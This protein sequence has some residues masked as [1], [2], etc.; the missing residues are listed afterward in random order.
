MINT[1]SFII[2]ILCRLG[3]PRARQVFS[4][5]CSNLIETLK[6]FAHLIKT[7]LKGQKVIE[8]LIKIEIFGEMGLINGQPR[9]EA[10]KALSKS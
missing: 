10:I 8:Q 4:S 3:P 5:D 6:I 2:R 7:T 9:S 1:L